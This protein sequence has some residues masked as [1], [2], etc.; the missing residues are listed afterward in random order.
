MLL[1]TQRTLSKLGNVRRDILIG[2]VITLGINGNKQDIRRLIWLTNVQ[3]MQR[4]V[5]M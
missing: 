1:K 2:I 5:E 4:V 3:R